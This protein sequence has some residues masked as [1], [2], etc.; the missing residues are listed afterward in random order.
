VNLLSASVFH[1][2]IPL[3]APAE[4]IYL[5]SE[6]K[7]TVNTSLVCP[8]NNLLVVPVL[9]SQSLRVLSQDDEIKK[10]LSYDNDKSLTK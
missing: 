7:A 1:N 3:S 4:M 10:L 9:K 6:E 2:L 5:L 8:L